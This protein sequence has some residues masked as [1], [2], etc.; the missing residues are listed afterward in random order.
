MQ[1][2][3]REKMFVARRCT[4]K[5]V[6]G[7]SNDLRSAQSCTPFAALRRHGLEMGSGLRDEGK[8]EVL[9][10]REVAGVITAR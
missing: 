5:L 6:L 8:T 1:V 2:T 4:G 3:P 10:G 7:L 9:E